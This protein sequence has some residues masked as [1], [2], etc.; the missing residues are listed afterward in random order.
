MYSEF[1]KNQ[2][3]SLYWS[4]ISKAVS[5]TKAEY[6]R[7]KFREEHHIIPK[8]MIGDHELAGKKWNKV[9]MSV[10]EHIMAH[11][12]LYISGIQI[13]PTS[14]VNE[15]CTITAAV[16]IF[17][18]KKNIIDVFKDGDFEKAKLFYGYMIDEG[19]KSLVAKR[20]IQKMMR[21]GYYRVDKSKLK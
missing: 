10:R 15:S 5:R 8:F 3:L 21:D 1:R 16:R 9:Y 18:T 7:I 19:V 20:I 13:V 14:N 6:K 2:A 17:G 11:K 12:L 4:L